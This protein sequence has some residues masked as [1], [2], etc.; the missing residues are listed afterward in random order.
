MQTKGRLL[1][2][3]GPSG[4]GKG[5]VVRY[6]V[7]KVGG[8]DLSV[9]AT[10]RSPREGEVDKVHYYFISDDEFDKLVQNGG[11]LEHA[12]YSK[13]SYGTPKAPVQKS[14]SDGR[15]MILE[16]DICG[17]KQVKSNFKDTITV[18]LVP[19]TYAE[20]KRRLV[21]RKTETAE[22]IENRLA[23]AMRE[24][25]EIEYFDYI[26]VNDTVE[27]AAERI[28]AIVRGEYIDDLDRR[29]FVKDFMK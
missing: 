16:I 3:S 7:N 12:R 9:S 2:V 11:L 28:D 4:S 5:T 8:Y 27:A 29:Q 23:I 6:L 21:D 15:N 10:T 26:V 14:L 1:T 13:H 24:L 19:P 18:M 17:A 22:E 20:L 25:E